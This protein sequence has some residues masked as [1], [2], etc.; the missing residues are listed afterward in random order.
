M[1]NRLPQA[2]PV[3]RCF[4]QSPAR[5]NLTQ[6]D[7][8][9]TTNLSA[10]LSR[11]AV[12][13]S[14]VFSASPPLAQSYSSPSPYPPRTG[15]GG[16]FTMSS[17][18][19]Q[20][21]PNP[22]HQPYAFNPHR[23]HARTGFDGSQYQ[24]SYLPVVHHPVQPYY[25]PHSTPEGSPYP[26][27]PHTS[28]SPQ[29][30]FGNS[31]SSHTP[32]YSAQHY[33]PLH[34]GSPS[35]PFPYSQHF[36]PG[37]YQ[38]YYMASAPFSEGMQMQYPGHHLM[39]YPPHQHQHHRHAEVEGL[40]GQSSERPLPA[41][42]VQQS[43][44]AGA[45]GR[46]PTFSQPVP[47]PVHLPAPPVVPSAPPSTVPSS[48]T[49]STR[50]EKGS[51]AL[52][53]PPPRA[54][55][56]RPAI[57]RPY[58][59]NPP[60]NRSEW[61]MWVGNVPGD[62]THD[63]LWRFLKRPL[64]PEPGKNE[65]A[66][67]ACNG[68]TSIFLISRSNCAFV[69][70]DTGE[71]LQRAITKFNGQQLR[72]QDRKCPRLVCRARRRE[73]DLRAGVG[74]Q[75]GMGVHTEYIRKLRQKEREEAKEQ[76]SSSTEDNSSIVSD[77]ASEISI[78]SQVPPAPSDEDTTKAKSSTVKARSVSSY[79]STNSS[80]LARHFPKR[81]FILKSLTRY[82]LDLSVE[83]GLW[84]TQKHNEV[85]LDQ[86]YRTSKDVILIFGVNKSGEFYGYARMASR[87]LRGESSVSWASRSDVS[88][89]S[90]SS[91]QNRKQSQ[92]TGE[93][94]GSPAA[95]TYSRENSANYFSPSE[96]RLVEESPLPISSLEWDRIGAKSPAGEERAQQELQSAP[97]RFGPSP[98]LEFSPTVPTKTFSLAE[99]SKARRAPLWSKISP[100]VAASIPARADIVL[101]RN[102]PAKAVRN[103][104]NA[105][106][107]SLLQA[108]QE[109]NL[110]E[111]AVGDDD[112]PEPAR[113][114]KG[115]AT[116]GHDAT[117]SWG[118]T[119]KVEWLCTQPLSFQKTRQ[120][121]NPWNHDREIKVSRDGT[122]LEPSVGQQ[123]IDG[124]ATL[125]ATAEESRVHGAPKRSGKS[126][127]APPMATDGPSTKG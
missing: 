108:V 22:L 52:G 4:T 111:N 63:E 121:R 38:W 112:A 50:S 102:A 67:V 98:P 115:A 59:P 46:K 77:A 80:F 88:P 13:P 11:S 66:D 103:T 34:Y 53:G 83:R 119:F 70:F 44:T 43:S 65:T 124:W 118:Q 14:P 27:P 64:S 55:T 95:S 81:F 10:P 120:L 123:L 89:C 26:P 12:G 8:N 78:Q 48:P 6:Q 28:I 1:Q 71:N 32:P 91:S 69:N 106:E 114:P 105:D 82:D 109:E 57:R 2:A 5:G 73:D 96:H 93:P 60:S 76:P 125:A 31:R 23:Y 15:F 90:V 87:V 61:V 33:Q 84:A 3:P 79:A 72:P 127:V 58:H 29:S 126:T 24:Q 97:A 37:P 17:Q 117:D 45:Q 101:D 9:N 68:V 20:P 42:P 36:Q 116:E 25:Q 107:S 100:S 122:E 56:E 85:V 18:H 54:Q 94:P 113:F 75:R 74:G 62:T 51:V 35:S 99:G 30:V 39:G 47:I 49:A 86:A 16:P 21:Y 19:P 7:P 104:L 41:S 92:T 110:T 40:P